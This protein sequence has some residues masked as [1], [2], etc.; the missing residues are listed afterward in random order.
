MKITLSIMERNELNKLLAAHTGDMGTLRVVREAREDLDFTEE[1]LEEWAG[2][3]KEAK[4][5]ELRPEK[6]R[7]RDREFVLPRSLV[8]LLTT[9]LRGLNDGKQLS[10]SLY[11]LV[12]KTCPDLIEKDETEKSDTEV[13]ANG[14][15]V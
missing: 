6:C 1:E 3:C 12:E 9:K 5:C 2:P 13:E 8:K 10:T 15:K 11:T 7:H 14:V 4:I